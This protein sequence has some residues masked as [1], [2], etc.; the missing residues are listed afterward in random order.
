MS[1]SSEV[2]KELLGLNIENKCCEKG[3]LFGMLQGASDLVLSKNNTRIIVKSYLL[4]AI[5][6]TMQI[7]KNNYNVETII[8]YGDVDHLNK[9]RYYYLEIKNQLDSIIKEYF[10]NPFAL[11]KSDCR[12]L[13]NDCCKNAFLRALF[14]SRG[15]INDPRKNCYHLE[16]TCHRSDL[17]ILVK[18]ILANNE[19]ESKIRER[20]NNYVVY[21]KKS[22]CISNTL[23]LIGAASGV[24]YFEDSRIV[25]DLSNMAN[26][27]TNCDIANVKKSTESARKQ[28]KAIEYIRKKGYFGKMPLRLQTMALMREEYPDSTLEELAEYSDNFFGKSLTKSGISHCL[29]SLVNYYVE[30]NSK[31]MTKKVNQLND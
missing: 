16:I 6:K 19:I 14:I 31:E 22:E 5:Q 10:L 13:E 1:F 3:F 15:S 29:R 25:R 20:K 18:E 30:L 28:L 4:P 24:F 21:V 23:A 7:I 9:K 11:I 27:M 17:A 12:I 8:K 2:K 26:R